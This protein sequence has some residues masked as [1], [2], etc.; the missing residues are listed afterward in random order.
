[1]KRLWFLL[2][3]FQMQSN[4]LFNFAAIRVN[5]LSDYSKKMTD[6]RAQ[7]LVLKTYNRLSTRTQSPLELRNLLRFKKGDLTF[8]YL[9]VKWLTNSIHA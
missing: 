2:F 9:E 3:Y 5:Q 8:Q 6:E 7:I 4:V 1:M